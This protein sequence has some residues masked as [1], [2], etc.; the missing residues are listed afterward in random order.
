MKYF[1]PS[2][3]A[4]CLVLH[5]DAQVQVGQDLIGYINEDDY[6]GS[7]RLN[8]DGHRVIIGAN[9]YAEVFQWDVNDWY[10]VGSLLNSP[11]GNDSYANC[12]DL[13]PSGE[14]ILVSDRLEHYNGV[15]DCGAVR[16]YGWEGGDWSQI[17]NT[18]YGTTD[19]EHLGFQARL[20]ESGSVVVASAK[21]FGLSTDLNMVGQVRRYHLLDDGTWELQSSMVT[22]DSEIEGL[23]TQLEISADASRLC[24]GGVGQ[25]NG[26]RVRTY[27][28]VEGAWQSSSEDIFIQDQIY[29]DA[30]GMCLSL[31]GDGSRLVVATTARTNTYD[32]VEGVGWELMNS[33]NERAWE[34]A[35]SFDGS[36]MAHGNP[37]LEDGFGAMRYMV[38]EDNQWNQLSYHVG[39]GT[40]D[41]FGYFASISEDGLRYSANAVGA[42]ANGQSE[43]PGYVRIYESVNDEVILG[44]TDV[45]ACN[46]D[47]DA[48][49]ADYSCL[50]ED[51]LGDCGGFCQGDANQNGICDD[52]E[53]G[54]CEGLSTLDYNGKTYNLVAIGEHCWF[55]EN[56]ASATFR[57]GDT[58]QYVAQGNSWSTQ[59]IPRRGVWNDDDSLYAIAGYMY[60]YS[61][62]VDER[63]LCPAG[64]HVPLYADYTALFDSLGTYAPPYRSPGLSSDGSGYWEGELNGTNEIG[65]A[66]QPFGNRTYVG[67]D[68]NW[69]TGTA[70]WCASTGLPQSGW[71]LNFGTNDVTSNLVLRS[72]GRYVRCVKGEYAYG[73]T[74]P[75]S[76]LY[77][78][79]A[80]LNDGSCFVFGCTDSMACNYDAAAENSD[81]SCLYLDANGE[82]T[83]I[84]LT[85]CMSPCDTTAFGCADPMACNFS[86]EASEN[87]D[88]IYP[89]LGASDCEEGGVI[90]GEGTMWVPSLQECV[91][92]DSDDFICDLIYDGTGDGYVG[93]GD[94]LGLLTEFGSNCLPSSAFDCGDPVGYQGYD[95]QTVQ[96]GN[97]CW[98]AENLRSQFYQNGDSIPN[99]VTGAEWLGANV[100]ETGAWC[101]HSG[102]PSGAYGR[103]YNWY[104][105]GDGRGICPSDWHVPSTEEWNELTDQFGGASVAAPFLKGN[106]SD[107]WTG[108]G[109]DQ[110][111]A[112]PGGFRDWGNAVFFALGSRGNWWTSSTQGSAFWRGMDENSDAV[113]GALFNKRMGNSI[114]CIRD[115]E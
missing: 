54:P 41:H 39:T 52:L 35:L 103:L 75:N 98:F 32:W 6:G 22:G 51:V 7:H 94:L 37:A 33:W 69:G 92:D 2:L 17:G 62:V 46:Y 8:Q 49:V 84:D 88:C 95:Y 31:S 25:G 63:E 68:I 59:S 16:V 15:E 99:F 21:W 36:K 4:F 81:G 14:I 53:L 74:D 12:V 23:G 27:D 34:L 86:E 83:C 91:V 3:L 72:R 66:V 50:Y 47:C 13:V 108:T 19:N 42:F 28:W 113:S 56:L 65:M 101:F 106:H 1:I 26:G 64:W 18:I 115:A 43:I 110:F 114:R 76:D 89:I 55:E 57:N 11:V 85:N 100:T 38:W 29:S 96:I 102:D 87:V 109:T 45:E 79:G 40:E 80:E 24:V 9:G 111:N 5:V 67:E 77:D 60:N 73:C 71:A 61:A 70:F 112:L 104:V 105:I 93:A 107:T 82:C 90:C 20:N 10:Q 30:S 44:C 48:T 97:Q 78:S 58:I